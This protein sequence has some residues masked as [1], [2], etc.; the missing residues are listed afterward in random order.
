MIRKVFGIVLFLFI[1][2]FNFS[3]GFRV[4]IFYDFP[5]K[6]ITVNSIKGEY[7]VMGDS[8][9]IKNIDQKNILYISV[10]QDYL[11][12]RDAKGHLGY[13]SDFSIIS[14]DFTSNFKIKP[15]FPS[16]KERTYEGNLHLK[17]DGH[18]L[19]AVN[20]L[21]PE[22]YVVS[23]VESEAGINHTLEYYKV[24]AIISRT[25]AYGHMSK[26]AVDNFNLCDGVHC[27]VFRHNL[28]PNKVI[29]KAVAETEDLVIT[30]SNNKLITAAFHSSS[31]GQTANSED[32]W[33]DSLSYL[34]S[35]NDKFSENQRNATWKKDIPIS[36]W[37]SYMMSKGIHISKNT[38]LSKYEFNQY[39]RKKYYVFGS[40]SIALRA[41]R[42]D[43]GLRSTFFSINALDNKM[44]RFEGKGYGHGVGLSQIGAMK[45]SKMGYGYKEIIQF[46][47]KG[48]KVI[49]FNEII[50]IKPDT[51]N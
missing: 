29:A 36:E 47:Y 40:D 50:Y 4:G 30:D 27:Q 43:L 11:K 46:Y 18:H 28:N 5:L 44:L 20:Q 2:Q 19:I 7:K 51:I 14:D 26:H 1:S 15:V 22:S 10:Y 13:Y 41:I 48:V 45:M 25:Y 39:D 16:E 31:G 38:S 33:I 12:V 37:N 17:S 8:V 35:I 42:Q 34:R 9:F 32:V 6:T 3:Q 21:D 24:Q 23:V 49:P